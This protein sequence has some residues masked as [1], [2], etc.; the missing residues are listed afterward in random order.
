MR[1]ISSSVL[2]FSVWCALALPAAAQAKPKKT[3]ATAGPAQ[4]AIQVV[5]HIAA[6][7]GA[8][9]RFLTT[10]HYSSY[11]LYAERQAGQGI[12]LVDVTKPNAP[13]V[14][15]DIPA[16]LSGGADSLTVVAGTA[17][18]VSD[19]AVP[20]A[21]ATQ[22]LRIMDFADPAHPKVTREFANVTAMA[23]DDRRGLIFLANGEGIWILQQHLAIDPEVEKAYGNYVIYGSSMYPPGK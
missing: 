5:G 6:S 8:V 22:T 2:I 9:T 3:K 16:V 19:A 14:L 23:R 21:P 18:L 11:Y 10:Q 15:S 13:N 1:Y 4:D 12:T 20:S 17:A 7:G